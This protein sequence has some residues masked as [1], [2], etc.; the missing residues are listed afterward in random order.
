MFRNELY[1]SLWP[2]PRIVAIGSHKLT[3]NELRDAA[4]RAYPKYKVSW[5]WDAREPNQAVEIWLDRK[6]HKKQRL[7]DPFTGQDLG[8][9]RPHSIQFPFV[10]A[11]AGTQLLDSRWSLPP[12]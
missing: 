5:I 2:G 9:S 12:T 7:F 10:P 11:K 8:E 4:L 6:G 1:N 3:H